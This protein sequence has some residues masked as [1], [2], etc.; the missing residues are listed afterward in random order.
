MNNLNTENPNNY[1]Y[2]TKDIELHILGG[3]QLNKL[4]SLRVTL[5]IEKLTKTKAVLNI[6]HQSIDLHNDN[7][8]EKLVRK[9]AERLEIG[10]FVIRK[11]LQE[12]TKALENHRFLLNEKS[13]ELQ[14]PF[15]LARH[16]RTLAR[17]FKAC[18]I[19]FSICNAFTIIQMYVLYLK[20]N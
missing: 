3:L 15:S 20:N 16:L 1:L 4:E 17:F 2:E 6:L 9:C 8:V 14:K 5:S 13:N 19:F 18:L 12:L 7:Q 10:T 11:T